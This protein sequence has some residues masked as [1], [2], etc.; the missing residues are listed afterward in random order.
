MGFITCFLFIFVVPSMGQNLYSHTIVLENANYNVSWNFNASSDTFEFL[1]KVRATGWVGFGFALDAPNN[2]NDYDVAV[3]GV[4]SNGTS[5]LQVPLSLLL[6]HILTL[7]FQFFNHL[8]YFTIIRRLIY[9]NV[10][11]ICLTAPFLLSTWIARLKYYEKCPHS[12]PT[13]QEF[14]PG[15]CMQEEQKLKLLQALHKFKKKFNLSLNF[16]LF[17]DQAYINIVPFLFHLKKNTAWHRLFKG[18]E[19]RFV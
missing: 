2:M 3:G 17:S 9:Q 4:F 12:Y 5:Y 1:L 15:S 18:H 10:S 11:S 19:I 6:Y 13:L 16:L 8:F 7:S 14:P